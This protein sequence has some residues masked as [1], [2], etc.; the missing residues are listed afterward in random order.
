MDI[1]HG[2]MEVLIRKKENPVLF[3]FLTKRVQSLTKVYSV[4]A[5]DERVGVCPELI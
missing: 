2:V 5:Y 1:L 3:A 4:V